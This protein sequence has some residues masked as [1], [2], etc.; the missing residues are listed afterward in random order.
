MSLHSLVYRAAIAVVWLAT[1]V[2]DFDSRLP[3]PLLKVPTKPALTIRDCLEVSSVTIEIVISSDTVTFS[4]WFSADLWNVPR[5]DAC[6]AQDSGAS[7]K[8]QKLGLVCTSL[9][10]I[11]LTMWLHCTIALG[12][13]MPLDKVVMYRMIQFY[14]KGTPIFVNQYFKVI[15]AWVA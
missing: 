4:S 7:S 10:L 12:W 9:N 8:A 11:L 1:Y 3:Q 14:L 15:D 13:S 6:A 5:L 2:P